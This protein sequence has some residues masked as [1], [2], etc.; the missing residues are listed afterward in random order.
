MRNLGRAAT[1]PI[2]LNWRDPK[3]LIRLGILAAV[4]AAI[5]VTV[6]LRNQLDLDQVGY[7]AVALAVLVASGGLALP[8]P[9]LATACT[10]ATFLNPALIGLIA[11][12]VGT[13]GELTGYFLGFTGRSVFNR[14]RLYIKLESWMSRRGWLVLLVLAAIPNPIFDLAGIAA[15]IN[16]RVLLILI[17]HADH[18]E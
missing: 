15:L 17:I 10:A 7:G 11:G 6:L 16:D 2:H 9:A 5:L 3:T 12:S 1:A 18:A 8:V 4:V 14:S 13:V